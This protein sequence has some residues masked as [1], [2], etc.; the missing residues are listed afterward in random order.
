MNS[1]MPDQ[2]QK[3]VRMYVALA[4]EC[5]GPE[6]DRYLLDPIRAGAAEHDV[7]MILHA[8]GVEN[9]P[10]IGIEEVFDA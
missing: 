10:D 9:L 4:Y 7:W 3:A 8:A 2:W 6:I 1:V 5:N